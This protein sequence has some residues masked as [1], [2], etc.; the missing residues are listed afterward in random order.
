MK[1]RASICPRNL[2]YRD[3]DNRSTKPAAHF[4]LHRFCAY[5]VLFPPTGI[6][7]PPTF[8]LLCVSR[9]FGIYELRRENLCFSVGHSS[10]IPILPLRCKFK[11]DF[12]VP[13]CVQILLRL[14]SFCIP[15]FITQYPE[16][17]IFR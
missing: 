6:T 2:F 4:F 8:G 10:K 12:Y 5:G 9:K 7:K 16:R 11:I 14:L 1:T 3:R 15:T 17:E 13:E